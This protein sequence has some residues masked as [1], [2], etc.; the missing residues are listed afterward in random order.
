M[1]LY[2]RRELKDGE[3]LQFVGAPVLQWARIQQAQS[4]DD[5]EGVVGFVEVEDYLL[6]DVLDEYEE[7]RKNREESDD[8]KVALFSTAY[9]TVVHGHRD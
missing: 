5:L 4:G 2:L 6:K 1:E 8:E 7:L 3:A 9:S